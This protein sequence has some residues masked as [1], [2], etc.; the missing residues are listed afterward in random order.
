MR[1]LDWLI[2]TFID[3]EDDTVWAVPEWHFLGWMDDQLVGHLDL[4]EREIRIGTSIIRVAGIGG[5]ITKQEWRGRGFASQ[6][7]E[8]AHKFMVNNLDCDFG[9][10]MCDEKVV[11]FYQS[12]GW[13][14]IP[15]VL[16]YDQPGGKRVF[17]DRI[18]ALPLKAMDLPEGDID[19]QGPPW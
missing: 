3:E 7:M 14:L 5:V 1:I 15:S 8:S 17:D 6:L 18:M 4:L 10:L 16:F 2:A 12:L 11:P 9:L 19:L 13:K